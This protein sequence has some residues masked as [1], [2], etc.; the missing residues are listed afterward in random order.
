MKILHKTLLCSVLIAVP[1]VAVQARDN[2]A[3]HR[4]WIEAQKIDIQ[5]TITIKESEIPADSAAGASAPGSYG[6]PVA[7]GAQPYGAQ[8]G[9]PVQ[10]GYTAPGTS[11][12]QSMPGASTP[13]E[14]RPGMQHQGGMR[15]Q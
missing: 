11:N 15:T 10:P 14:E 12:H 9:Q 7:P 6:Q 5:P 1:M 13:M 3:A 2:D 8:P 4:A